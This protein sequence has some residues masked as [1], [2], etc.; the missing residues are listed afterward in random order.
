MREQPKSQLNPKLGAYGGKLTVSGQQ[1]TTVHIA[2]VILK[3]LK[4]YSIAA[5]FLSQKELAMIKIGPSSTLLNQLHL[6][7]C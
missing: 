7:K 4:L 6:R 3:V 1:G 5:C 2:K